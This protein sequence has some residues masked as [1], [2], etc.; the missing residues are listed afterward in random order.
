MVKGI[1]G[2]LGGLSNLVSGLAG[3]LSEMNKD[4]VKAEYGK[5]FLDDEEV[6]Q[7]YSLI[8]DLVIF[9]NIRMI[10]L[11]NKVQLEERCLLIQCSYEYC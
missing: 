9:T 11:I 3:N 1:M 10:I 2:N 4:S 5:Y 8:R 7:A 6:V